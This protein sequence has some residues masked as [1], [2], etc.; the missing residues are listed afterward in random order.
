M[1]FATMGSGSKGNATLVDE[2]D[3]ALLVDCGLSYSRVRSLASEKNYD[4]DKLDGIF[5]THEH[6]DHIGGVKNLSRGLKIPVYATSGTIAASGNRFDDVYELKEIGLDKNITLGPFEITPVIVPHDAQEPCQFII[7]ARFKRLGILTDLGHVTA[8]VRKMYGTLD[9]LVIE[10]NHDLDMLQ[11]SDYRQILQR[12][13]SGPYGHLSNDQAEEFL[14]GINYQTMSHLVAAHL[15]EKTNS[16]S[17]VLACLDR[18]V[19]STVNTYVATQVDFSPW[20][21]ISG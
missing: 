14:G 2:N 8:Y 16:P 1:R 11:A 9:A 13:I 18:V 3:S 17:I 19:P 15:S 6:S 10:F 21:V 4:L 5:V 7:T 20:F 12:R